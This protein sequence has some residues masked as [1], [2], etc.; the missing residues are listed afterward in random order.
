MHLPTK[1]NL[2]NK[3]SG[4]DTMSRDGFLINMKWN[5]PVSG[6]GLWRNVRMAPKPNPNQRRRRCRGKITGQKQAQIEPL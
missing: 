4:P 2:F 1:L 6:S 3:R 5:L